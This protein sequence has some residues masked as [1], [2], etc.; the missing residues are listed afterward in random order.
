[1]HICI[2]NSIAVSKDSN[3]SDVE[4][5]DTVTPTSS[6]EEQK[7]AKPAQSRHTISV[8]ARV[9]PIPTKVRRDLTNH[10]YS[11]TVP[12]HQKLQMIRRAK[13]C[14]SSDARRLLWAGP[15]RADSES[16]VTQVKPAKWDPWKDAVV[17]VL[18]EKE[19]LGA[20]IKRHQAVQKPQP[21]YSTA[22]AGIVATRQTQIVICAPSAGIR[23]Y[24]L[25]GVLDA[26]VRQAQVFE[27]AGLHVVTD[28][29]NGFNGTI[30]MFGQTGSGKTHTMFG[31]DEDASCSVMGPALHPQRGMIPRTIAEVLGYTA[32]CE[33]YGR[34]TKLRMAY[35]EVHGNEVANLLESGDTVGAWHGVAARAVLEGRSSILVQSPAEAEELLRLGENNKRRAATAMNERSTRAHTILM[36]DLDQIDP[37]NGNVIKSQLCLADL[38]GYV[39]PN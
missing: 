29:L 10:G 16:N 14:S 11:V 17:P 5:F 13:G 33:R 32:L 2:E 34:Q 30:F 4:S 9:R 28:F 22:E 24:E 31:P 1:M 25:D 38:G 3:T 18:D 8:L 15:D 39:D 36:L 35:I 23:E 27:K 7:E 12:L 21:A 37:T 26:G 6:D 20:T 19:N